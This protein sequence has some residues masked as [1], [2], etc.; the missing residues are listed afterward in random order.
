[1]INPPSNSMNIK[2]QISSA[3]VATFFAIVACG[4]QA[5]QQEATASAPSAMLMDTM[6]SSVGDRKLAR[7]IASRLARTRGLN[8][9]QILVKAHDS[10]VT[11]NGS[12]SDSGQIPLAT[13]AARQVGGTVRVENRIRVAGASL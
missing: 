5:T 12:V 9:T 10:I 1:M 8:S 13:E 7:Q 2:R 11:L 3:L 6:A 4:A